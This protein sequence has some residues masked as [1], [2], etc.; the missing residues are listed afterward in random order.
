[1]VSDT[2]NISSESPV[3][4]CSVRRSCFPGFSTTHVSLWDFPVFSSSSK[5]HLYQKSTLVIFLLFTLLRSFI[6]NDGITWSLGFILT[7]HK[8]DSAL[9]SAFLSLLFNLLPDHSSFLGG[10]AALNSQNNFSYNT[11]CFLGF[12]LHSI[13]LLIHLSDLFYTFFTTVWH[14]VY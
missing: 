4:L 13:N 11:A 2:A 5:T 6:A 3:S 7:M 8:V 14:I 10:F 12:P 1:M 9:K